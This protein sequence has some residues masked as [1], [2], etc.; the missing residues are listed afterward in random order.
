MLGIDSE[1]MANS[2]QAVD[3]GSGG[4][5]DRHA[6]TKGDPFCSGPTRV[7]E[8]NDEKD[9]RRKLGR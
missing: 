4:G 7:T 8:V 1:Q 6:H 5:S 3:L 9:S 2:E